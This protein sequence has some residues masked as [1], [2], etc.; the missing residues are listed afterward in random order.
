LPKPKRADFADRLYNLGI[1][2]T[3]KQK[4][5]I[6]DFAENKGISVSQLIEY[7]VWQFIREDRGIAAPG[8]S[9]FAK[10]TPDDEVRSYLTGGV[11]LKPC[12]QINCAQQ[13]VMFQGLEFCETCN[14][15]I[16]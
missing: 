5:E 16:A 13:N 9:Q 8:P 7:A 15:R 2:I 11:L 3:G 10:T 4:N 12:G 14:L 1:R 6:I